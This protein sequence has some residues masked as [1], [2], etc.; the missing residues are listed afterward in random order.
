MSANLSQCPVGVN[1]I[2]WSNDDFQELGGATSLDTCLSEMREAGYAGSEL[3]HKFPRTTS[4][5]REALGRHQLRLVSGWHSTYFAEKPLESELAEARLHLNLLKECGATVFIA[6]E[7]S[8][9]IYNIA[10]APLGWTNDRPTLDTAGWERVAKGLTQLGIL[11]KAAGLEL[12]YHH[13]MGTVIQ[14]AA[15]LHQ[16]MTEVPLLGLLFDPGHL[17]FAGIDSSAVLQRYIGRIGHFHLK[18]VRTTVVARARAEKWSFRKAVVEGVYTIPG[19]GRPGD[20]SVNFPEAFERLAARNY[21]GWLVVEAEED[22]AKV[23]AL[24]KAKLARQYVRDHA[25]A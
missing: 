8:H 19:E 18:N 21:R 20:G 11:C 13:H 14:T 7:C 3:G 9:R 23:P 16:L 5:L 4:A 1:P 6:A 22:P 10:D 2:V 15:E 17:A 12:V 24:P 25:N